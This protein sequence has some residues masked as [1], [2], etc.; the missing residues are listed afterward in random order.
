MTLQ[1][2]DIHTSGKLHVNIRVS[3][4]Q[5]QVCWREDPDSGGGGGGMCQA[6]AHHLF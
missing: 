2:C 3:V 6:A 5:G 1:S 4:Q